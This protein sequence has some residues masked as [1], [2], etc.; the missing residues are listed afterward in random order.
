MN[1]SFNGLKIKNIENI[2]YPDGTEGFISL[3]MEGGER[4]P[5]YGMGD[6]VR[7]WYDI[8]GKLVYFP[9]AIHCFEEVDN[10]LHYAAQEQL[11]RNLLHYAEK[12]NNQLFMTT[13][14]LE[15]MD[16]LLQAAQ[17]EGKTVCNNRFVLSR[18]VTMIGALRIVSWMG[19]RLCGYVSVDWS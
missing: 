5:L 12:Y 10:G 6:G 7:R 11:S 9:D 1:L 8:V 16:A 19:R 13:H 14:N 3:L 15:Y 4:I 2:P 17:N 18:C